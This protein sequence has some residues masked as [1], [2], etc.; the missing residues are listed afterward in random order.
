MYVKVYQYP[1]KCVDETSIVKAPIQASLMSAEVGNL[2]LDL[3]SLNVRGIRSN[4]KRMTIFNWLNTHTSDQA[5]IFLQETHSEQSDENSWATQFSCEKI[6]YS[7]GQRNARGVLIGVR[8]NLDFRLE[9]IHS[10]NERRFLI[11]KCINQDTPFLLV[12]IYNVNYEHEQVKVL[13]TIKSLIYELDEEH[14][15]KVIAGGDFNFIQDTVL[16]SDGGSPS[17]NTTSIAELAQLQDSRDLIDIWRIRN[18]YTRRFTFRQ[19]TTL[20]QR[21]LDYFLISDILQENV[22]NVEVMPAIC[23]DHSSIMLRFSNLEKYSRGSSYWKFN[24]ALLSDTVYINSMKEKIDEFCRINFFPDDPRLNWEFVKFKIKEFTRKYSSEKKK[25]DVAE[26]S[27]LERKFKNLSHIINANSSV[28]TRK[29]YEDCKNRLESFSDN[30][31]KG[32]ILRSKAEWYEK[33]EKSNK[34]FYNLEK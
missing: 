16:D 26:R 1:N 10:D 4:G 22:K 11:L 23:T 25:K 28:E 15:Y 24:N 13:Q 30:I 20:I 17:L 8:K 21:R 14:D 7:H 34:Y 9:D 32:L 12:N 19:K 3:L 29:E 2:S 6:F 31:T 18:P 5:I 27:D 33:G